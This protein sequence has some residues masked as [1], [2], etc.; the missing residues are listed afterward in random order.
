M[1]AERT[2]SLKRAREAIG[3][4]QG[5]PESIVDTVRESLLVLDGN[6]RI[7][8][9][10]RSVY[11]SFQ[12]TPE[13]IEGQLIYELGN[14]QW[15]IPA[16][17]RLLGGISRERPSIE[18]FEVE[19]DFESIGRRTMLLNARRLVPVS[20]EEELILLAIEDMTERRRAEEAVR[21]LA[22]ELEQRVV[23]RTAQLEA[24]NKELEAFAHSVAH[25]LRA[26]LRAI[27]GFSRILL[28]DCGEQLNEEGKD[29]LKRVRAANQRMAQ[30]IDDILDLSRV[31]RS[32]MC[33][34]RVDLS[35]LAWSIAGELRQGE[36]E[37][38]VAFDITPGLAA[39]GDPQLLRVVLENLL[40]NAWKFTAAHERAR[41]EFGAETAEGKTVFFI[42][43]DGA[44]FDMHYA[45]KLFGAFQRLH[46]ATEF[47]GTGIGLAT[48]RRIIRRHGG[49]V[50]A[51][52]AVERGA[53]FYF[54]LQPVKHENEL[55]CEKGKR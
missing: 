29:C 55:V 44:G 5:L 48:V 31:T 34:E 15:D 21:T 39:K 25:D 3:K 45:D 17:R 18:D 13:Q 30:L 52:G 43:D 7:R 33:H 1:V 50:W 41:I 24:A 11:R 49:R 22:E 38:E 42:R 4:T 23:Q 6:L 51:E 9:A 53:T 37:R 12:V 47:P 19:H 26:P 8:S 28:K 20:G 16:L 40:R 32:E 46:Q 36:P 27:D 10:N 14:G 54:T 35:A 2:E